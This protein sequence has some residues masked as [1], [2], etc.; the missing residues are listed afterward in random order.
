MERLGEVLNQVLYTKKVYYQK[1]NEGNK[2]KFTHKGKSISKEMA[3]KLT[4][5]RGYEQWYC[6]F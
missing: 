4:Q 2:I 1:D 5:L 3:D 6:P